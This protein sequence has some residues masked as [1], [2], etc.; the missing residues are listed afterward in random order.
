MKN[1][2]LSRALVCGALLTMAG[3]IVVPA[4]SNPIA[5]HAAT[6]SAV[7]DDTSDRSITLT[8]YQATDLNDHGEAGDGTATNPN[9]AVLQGVEFKLQRVKAMPG[10]NLSDASTAKEGT[11]YTIDTAFEAQTKTTDANGK[12]TWD[13]GTGKANDGIYLVTEVNSSSAVDPAT[14]KSVEVTTPSAPFFVQVPMTN[15]TSSSDLIYAVVVEPKNVTVNALEPVKT[16][17]DKFGDAVLAGN[18]FEWELTSNIPSGLYSTAKAETEVPMVDK[19]G[20]PLYDASGNAIV[21][22]FAAGDVIYIE[23]DAGATYYD[24]SGAAVPADKIVAVSNFTM[25]DKLNAN[26]KYMGATVWA[27]PNGASDYV[28]LP[29][30]Y[31]TIAAPAVGSSGTVTMKLTKAGLAKIND[32]EKI[33]THLITKLDEGFD[34]L[35]PN[36]FEVNYQTPGGKPTTPVTPPVEPKTYT[37]GFNLLKV[38][39]G[40]DSKVLSGAIFHIASNEQDAK[41]GKFLAS[42]GKSYTVAEAA[43]AGVTLLSATTNAAGRA[44]FDGLPLTW[45][46]TNANGVVDETAD[47]IERDYWVVETTAPKGYELLKSPQQIKVNLNT[48]KDTDIELKVEDEKQ[49]NLPFTGGV[50]TTLMVTIALGAIAIGTTTIVINKKRNRSEA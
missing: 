19:D 18:T 14:G 6:Q 26:L 49:T 23:P 36:T 46:D 28:E 10:K 11:D 42:D 32:Y 48:A 4:I 47:A 9:R 27:L 33:S 20:N 50:G 29:A 35:I 12:I 5:V 25:V 39:K 1:K 43:T 13:L 31:Y 15:R 8:K 22:T 16:I 30:D 34:G 40:D 44:D 7:A 21:K 17:N 3:T 24:A 41:D 45:T 37:G 2:A 38:E